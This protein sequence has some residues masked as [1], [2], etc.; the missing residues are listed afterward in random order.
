MTLFWDATGPLMRYAHG[1][2]RIEDLNPQNE[3]TWRMSRFEMLS[4]GLRC[5]LAALSPR[6]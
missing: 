3:M 6:R 5:I 4:L 1:I 2:L